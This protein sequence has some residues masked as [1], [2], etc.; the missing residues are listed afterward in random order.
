MIIRPNELNFENEKYN[1]LI[2]G[3]PG[4][5]KTTLA[6]SAPKP[7]VLDLDKGI[8][9]VNAKF[10]QT[11]SEV[12][13]YEELLDDLENTDLSEFETIVVDT[14]ARLLGLMKD[15]AIR[16]EPKNGQT[17]GNLTLKG[18]GVVGKE[19]MKF[20]NNIKYKYHK[21]CV[22]IFH[23]SEQ[24]DNDITKLRISIEGQSKD[25]IW[26]PMDLGGFME[27]IGKDHTIGFT[28]CERYFAKGSHGIKGIWTIPNP[29]ETGENNFLTKLFEKMTE[30]LQKESEEANKTNKEYENIMNTI[31]P[32]IDAMT[33]ENI[34]DVQ[35]LIQNT[36]HISTSAKELK[37]I[38]KNKLA[39]LEM[40][41]DKETKTYV[42]IEK[43]KKEK[44]NE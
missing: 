29:E 8:S 4:I 26:Q 43:A 19:F 25:N 32:K 42:K 12:Q 5:G 13:T 6:C 11:T 18:Y 24:K 15:W 41:W 16:K 10:R 17:D 39:E 28:N 22:V 33:A 34:L 38:F 44:G 30:Q 3:F 23:C 40:K 14:G 2:A 36:K 27:I 35:T 31:K 21:H 20:V 1:V 9:R 37:N 7:L